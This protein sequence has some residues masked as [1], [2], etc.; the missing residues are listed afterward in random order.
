MKNFVNEE[1]RHKLDRPFTGIIQ[2][3]RIWEQW[4]D[5][6]VFRMQLPKMLQKDYLFK[7]IGDQPD[8]III[9]NRGKYTYTV[10]QF[11]QLIKKY[12]KS[13]YAAH[14]NRGDVIATIGL[15]TPELYAIKYAATS[16]GLV[17]CNLDIFDVGEKDQEGIN[18]LYK[19][20]CRIDPKMI[21]TLDY[22]EDK[23]YKVVNDPKFDKALKISM[24][25]S[26]ST[27]KYDPERLVLSLKLFKDFLQGKSVKGKISLDDFLMTGNNIKYEDV[28]ECY[29]ENQPC[30]IAFT[31]GTM[32]DSK[33]VLISHDANNALA[34]QQEA[35]NF[36]FKVGSKHLALLPPFLAFWDAD[37]V[38][39]TLCLGAQNIL[40]LKISEEDIRKFFLKY[41]GINL[42]I[43]PQSMWAALQ[44]LP[45]KDI[46]EIAK[47][48]NIA[49]VGGTRCE[50]SAAT[51]FY[52][53][54]K[55][56]QFTGY[57]ASEMDTTFSVT[58]PNCNKIGSC[59]LPLPF[60]NVRIV[61]DSL[62]DLTYNQ[63][64][65]LHLTG[66]AMMNGYY[67]RDDLTKEVTYYDNNGVKWYISG[68]YAV[69]DDDGCMT[70]LD[71]YS[72]PIIIN[73]KS[74]QLLDVAEIIRKNNNVRLLKLSYC[75][76]KIVLHL[77][78]NKFTNASEEE[79]ISSIINTIKNEVAPDCWPDI[80]IVREMPLTRVGKVDY[81]I[82]NKEAEELSKKINNTD[83]LYIIKHE[84]EKKKTLV[85]EKK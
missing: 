11:E 33:A 71:R 56:L 14:L 60:N 66:P 42:G 85:K 50:I 36:G 22:L 4:Y 61:D 57:G 76:S 80:I 45:E 51:A 47:D 74:V 62:K 52:T 16:V 17:T 18:K 25:L 82:L 75:N 1:K 2:E 20:L 72:K 37:V 12:E 67:G 77:E 58:H 35:A 46:E 29:S 40:E 26:Y 64:G 48:L 19:K 5:P 43:W 63:P 41:K 8:R 13:F 79:A 27:P 3:D 84:E 21:F 65:Q 83:K 31:S 53:I 70:V 38:H 73:S 49:I 54:L 69:M 28:V 9:N 34:F 6:E 59:G 24:P 55:V 81:P 44:T 30:N 10:N 32:G 7:C 39:V 15:T 78:V 23:I 68:D